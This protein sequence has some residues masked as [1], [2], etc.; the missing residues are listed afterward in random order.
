MLCQYLKRKERNYLNNKHNNILALFIF[1]TPK[2]Y[3][4]SKTVTISAA[5]WTTALRLA[6]ATK[7]VV[8]IAGLMKR[9]EDEGNLSPEEVKDISNDME[10]I[11]LSLADMADTIS[12]GVP[13]EDAVEEEVMDRDEVPEENEIP[14]V[15]SKKD[16]SAADD[17]E[18]DK[19]KKDKIASLEKQIKN[20]QY[21]EA[22][23]DLTTK[24]GKLFSETIREAKEKEFGKDN[25]PIKILEAKYKE[26]SNLTK[27][28]KV[29]RVAMIDNNGRTSYI[30][31]DPEGNDSNG[32]LN[33]KGVI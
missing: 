15:E 26:A 31:D 32:Q 2:N 13:A 30:E 9:S 25:E 7:R 5:R 4:V 18:E 14:M 6:K 10:E 3:F 24:Y 20:L 12:E 16:K 1:Y 28:K 23:K 22:L 27:D 8:K 29:M 33:F 11:A 19:D 17:E 21:K